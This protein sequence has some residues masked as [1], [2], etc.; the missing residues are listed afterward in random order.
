MRDFLD[1]AAPALLS[2]R[3]WQARA[4]L[5]CAGAAVGL[6]AVLFARLADF[7][8]AALRSLL[9]HSWIWPLV[10]AP[11]GFFAIA[12][13]T[14]RYFRGAEGS[15]IPQTIHALRPGGESDA[16]LLMRA[17]VV[18]ARIV[19]AA[20]GLFCGGSI[21]REGPTVHVGAAIA[22]GMGRW[23]PHRELR[24]QRHLLILVGGAAGVAAAFNTPLAGIVFGI[25]ELARSFEERA[26]GLMLSTVVLAGIIAIAVA[27]DYSYFGHPLLDAGAARVSVGTIVV[28]MACGLAGGLFSR[29]ILAGVRGMPGMFG[30][31]QRGHAAVF[32]LCCGALVAVLGALT[33]GLTYGSGYIEAKS[34]LQGHVHLPWSYGLARALATLASYLSGVPCGLFAPSLS[35]GAGLGQWLADLMGES[36]SVPFAILGMSG[37]LAAVTQAPLTSLVIVTE[38]TAQH[39]MVFPLMITVSIATALSKL[40]SPPIYRA[41]AQ[42][43]AVTA[44]AAVPPPVGRS[45]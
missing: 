17:R 6:A 5:W 9:A 24:G 21:G 33:H 34:I 13:L 29:L 15:G 4:V 31:L 23:L 36:S 27:G 38:M 44:E 25:E 3:R 45:P 12:W 22:Y 2:V 26:S 39:E 7:A 11:G 32:A 16:P 37:Y 1:K 35:T 40:L 10:L 28:A 19:L 42:R 20:A 41:L 43:Y 30:R 14:R 8:Q 18:V